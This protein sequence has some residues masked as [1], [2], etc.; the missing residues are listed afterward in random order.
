MVGSEDEPETLVGKRVEIYWNRSQVYYAGE[1][2]WLD[3]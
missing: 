3:T 2:S 1:S